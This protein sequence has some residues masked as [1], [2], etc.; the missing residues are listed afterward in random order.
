M[1]IFFYMAFIITTKYMH[2]HFPRQKMVEFSSWS[3]K[4]CWTS[5]NFTGKIIIWPYQPNYVKLQSLLR[6]SIILLP[7]LKLKPY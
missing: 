7:P 5:T 2:K 3:F 6:N 1:L 4:L